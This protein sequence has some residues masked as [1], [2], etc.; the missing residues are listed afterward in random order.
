MGAPRY[1]PPTPWAELTDDE[2]RC[3][4][5]HNEA[6]AYRAAIVRLCNPGKPGRKTVDVAEVQEIAA[7]ALDQGNHWHR[8]QRERGRP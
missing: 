5:L 4:L 8:Q 7:R 3:R 1:L 6:S 2:R